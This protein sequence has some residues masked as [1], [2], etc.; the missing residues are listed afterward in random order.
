MNRKGFTLVEGL[1][2][3]AILAIMVIIALPN[4]LGMF[5]DAKKNTFETEVESIFKEA[6]T[7]FINDAVLGAG[8]R[9]YCKITDST[10]GSCPADSKELQLTTTKNYLVIMDSDGSV[11]YIGVA[12]KSFVFGSSRVETITD[13]KEKDSII[14]ASDSRVQGKFKLTSSNSYIENEET[15]FNDTYCGIDPNRCRK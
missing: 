8:G 10:Y 12:D 14:D 6:Q 9:T 4:V 5:N 1:A 2:V 11:S 3:I 15:D 13:I 7:D